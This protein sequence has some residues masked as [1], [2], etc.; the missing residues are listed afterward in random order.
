MKLVILDSYTAVCTGLEA[1]ELHQLADE[2]AVYEYTP[3]ELCAERIG[4]AEMVLINKALLPAET[5]AKCKNLRYVGLF[6]TGY[7]VVDVD[8]CKEHGIVVANVPGYSTPAV[9]QLTLGLML[10][11]SLL[12][13]KHDREVHEGKWT[14]SQT[15]SF[16]DP[17]IFE[18]QGKTLGIIGFGSI[19]RQVARLAEAFGMRMLVWSRTRYPEYEKENLQ[20]TSL[21]NLLAKSDIVTLHVPLFPETAGLMGAENLARM[22]PGAFLINTARG[23]LVDEAA[24]HQALETGALAGYGTDVAAI[25][26]IPADS[27]LLT[28]K[29]CIITPHIAWACRESRERLLQVVCENVRAFLAGNPQNNVAK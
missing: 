22:K 2:V 26:P 5:L 29:N 18:L 15:F 23:G 4:D 8:Y 28:A 11:F 14:V 1:G 7:N 6:A 9:A 12:L 24:I 27:P 16:Y 21:E 17:R 3:P 20:F 19:G 10:E 25:E 13:H